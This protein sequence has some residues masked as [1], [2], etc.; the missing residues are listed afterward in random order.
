MKYDLSILF[1]LKRAKADKKGLIPIYLRI[2]VNGE[3][4]ELSANR[5]IE[6]IK[7]DS[8]A[9][10]AKGRSEEAKALNSH[11]DQLE[12]KIKQCYN[13]LNDQEAAITGVL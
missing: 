10:R 5:K 4:S 3:R 7:W 2:T 6:L 12:T 9:Q 11:L 1:Y 13:S 8:I